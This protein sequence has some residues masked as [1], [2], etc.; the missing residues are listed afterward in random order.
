MKNHMNY[1]SR[2]I[3]HEKTNA[4]SNLVIDYV[5]QKDFLKHFYTYKPDSEGLQNAIAEKRKSG[6]NREL[7]V[8]A[9]LEQYKNID[10]SEKVKE[11]INRLSLENTFTICTAHQPNIFT[12]YL[13]F[14]YKILHAVKI[15]DE[16]TT[17]LPEN[18]Y[19][20]VYYMGSEDNDLAELDHITLSGDRLTWITDQ[21]GSVGRMHTKGMP[22][23]IEQISG[24]LSI[25]EH[26]PALIAALKKAYVASSTIQ[27][28]TL[29][30]VDFLFREY[31]LIV[32]IA[33]TPVL[34]RQMI[35]VFKDDLF[36]HTPKNI[37]EKTIKK[38][39]DQY[40]IQVNPR[41]INLFYMKD[42]IRERIV[43]EAELFKVNNTAIVF[44]KE[45]IE[46]ELENHPERFSPNVV[47]RGLYQETILPD[48]AFIGG[49]SEIAYWLELKDL[50]THYNVPFPVLVLR[51]SFL[52]IEEK[53][54]RLAER[55]GLDTE[56]LFPDANDILTAMVKAQSGRQLTLEKEMATLAAFYDE[57][58]EVSTAVDD[59][60]LQH[61]DALKTRAEKNLKNLEKKIIRA[62]K[63]K[64]RDQHAQVL[65]LKNNLFPNNNLQERVENIL[66]YYA[67]YGNAFIKMLYE[68]S[69]ALTPQFTVVTEL[70]Q[71]EK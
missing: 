3:K 22:E 30:F 56:D 70:Q 53:M 49:G 18:N 17:Q 15:A 19:V 57:V 23:V 66:P 67:K 44:T 6:V 29:Q 10:T 58:K 62:E 60:L 52:I 37:V 8:T 5:D 65:R 55:L 42:N 13:Y 24:R 51:N 27:E 71:K 63:R 28:A 21:T 26:G 4:F 36:H 9:L 34:K 20:P 61:V 12:G 11:N 46:Q 69:P 1:I 16:L 54:A 32:L 14:I 39:S 41:D 25:F 45:E 38:L 43:A 2:G 68:H 64:H 47:L 48:I 35:N 40:K 50:F 7:L 33:D 59:T 31:G